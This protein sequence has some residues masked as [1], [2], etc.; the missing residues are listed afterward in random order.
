MKKLSS[1]LIVLLIMVFSNNVFGQDEPPE[2]K[3]PKFDFDFDFQ[4]FTKMSKEDEDK[5]LS[6][7][8]EQLRNELK[9][10]KKVDV[11]K[12]FNFLRQSQ[13]KTMNI[14][15]IVKSEKEARE[16]ERKIFEAEIKTE[17]LAAKYKSSKKNE[18][19]KIKSELR[20]ELE[21]L[22]V[23]KENRRRDEVESLQ[24]ELVELQKSLAARQK[25]KTQIIERRL[26]E[27][28]SEKEYLEWN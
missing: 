10:I 7:L 27:L 18:K 19:E 6:N 3:P 21:K 1:C 4:N 15:F 13:Y 20:S 14:P 8:K 28:L 22:F 26:Q 9:E 12:Y 25:N 11:N 2:P 24:K 16:R 5:V 23:Q 17:S